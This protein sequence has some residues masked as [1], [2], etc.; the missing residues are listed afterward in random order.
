MISIGELSRRTGV[1]IETI[2][3]YERTGML[4]APKRAANGRRYYDATAV[5]RLL[6]LRQGRGLGF[7]KNEVRDLMCLLDE[8]QQSCDV[9]VELSRRQVAAIDQKI[10]QLKA[11]RRTLTKVAKSCPGLSVD[12]CSV[13][14]ALIDGL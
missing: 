5:Q 14:N 9:A 7:G 8:P 11:M 3:Y 12:R 4:P 13:L 10:A 6:V 1:V 2:R